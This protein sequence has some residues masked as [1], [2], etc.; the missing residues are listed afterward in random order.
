[1]INEKINAHFKIEDFNEWVKRRFPA[2][3]TDEEQRKA[4]STWLIW[5]LQSLFAQEVWDPTC[6]Y[7][8]ASRYHPQNDPTC[9]SY[10][11][12]VAEEFMEQCWSVWGKPDEVVLCLEDEL[13]RRYKV[14]V[15]AEPTISFETYESEMKMEE[16][17]PE[18]EQND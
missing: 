9:S 15:R 6:A 8:H 16:A 12:W 1:M 11:Q 13:G 7:K 14:R 10:A 2:N 3:M 5:D 4:R 18:R 17:W